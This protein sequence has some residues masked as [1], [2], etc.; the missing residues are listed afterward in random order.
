MSK[1]AIVTRAQTASYGARCDVLIFSTSEGAS[2]N[3]NDDVAS[4][5]VDV[6][7][8]EDRDGRPSVQFV[9]AP[10]QDY[11]DEM[12]ELAFQAVGEN[13]LVSELCIEHMKAAV[14]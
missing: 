5:A 8:R 9:M 3:D 2:D 6:R 12:Q 13:G 1:G 10:G 7:L 11:D 14:L 4:V